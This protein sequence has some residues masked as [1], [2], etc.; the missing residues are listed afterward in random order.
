MQECGSGSGDALTAKITQRDEIVSR[1][2]SGCR[3]LVQTC[4]N[5]FPGLSPPWR[6]HLEG[7]RLATAAEVETLSRRDG[8]GVTTSLQ[9]CATCGELRGEY[10]ALKGEGNGDERHHVV[11]VH[12]QC[13]NHNRC[14]RCGST[15]GATRLSS[16]SY[17]EARR[18]VF[19]SAAYTGL[20]HKCAHR[21]T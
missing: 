17:D 2:P 6:R 1:L 5:V 7:E 3:P 18:G 21:N 8:N 12:C 14:A 19:S 4:K 11:F 20:S 13:D 9:R 16:Y 15:L 10:L